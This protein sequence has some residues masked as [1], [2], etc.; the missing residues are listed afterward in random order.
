MIVQP[1]LDFGGKCE[2]AIEFYKKALGAKVEAVM[3]FKDA[4]DP[5]ML[6]MCPPGSDDK[7]MHA[8]L[9][10]G[11]SVVMMSDGMGTGTPKFAGITLSIGLQKEADA[12]R[13]FNALADGGKVVMP[14][15]KTFWS[16]RFGMVTDK[17]GVAWMINVEGP[18]PAL[19]P[20]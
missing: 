19:A 6:K 13:Y 9:T 18:K 11:K 16:P 10:F 15:S 7:I 14:L 5:E 8:S 4:P 17:F 20:K 12:D 1:Y 2:Q 3:R